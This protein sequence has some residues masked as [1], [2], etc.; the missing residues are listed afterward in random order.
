MFCGQVRPTAGLNNALQSGRVAGYGPQQSTTTGRILQSGMAACRGLQLLLVWEHLRLCCLTRRCCQ[1]CSAFRQ[2]QRLCPGVGLPRRTAWAS[3]AGRLLAA[4]YGWALCVGG[5]ASCTPHVSRAEDCAV[6]TCKV[7][8]WALCSDGAVGYGLQL[9]GVP[10]LLLC[11]NKTVGFVQQLGRA[12]CWA[13]LLAGL[14]GC[15]IP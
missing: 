11:L 9:R 1:L 2:G 3:L 14:R 10:D 12:I 13:L 8:A 15:V 5:A 4:L 7:S 6:Q